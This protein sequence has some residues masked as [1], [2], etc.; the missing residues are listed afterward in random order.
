MSLGL[1]A[2]DVDNLFSFHPATPE[3]GPLH[4]AVR[5]SCRDLAHHLLA[6]VPPSA[7][8]TTAIRKV[9]HANA[10]VA[11]HAGRER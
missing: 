7:E 10:G 11:C 3:T 6:I 5:D 8:R 1:D 9:M 2:S 4:D